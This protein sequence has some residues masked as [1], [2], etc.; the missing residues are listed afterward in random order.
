MWVLFTETLKY[1]H[2]TSSLT[3]N[4]EQHRNLFICS[5][6]HIYLFCDKVHDKFEVGG[7]LQFPI[8]QYQ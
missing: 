6:M 4:G 7:T 3:A 8:R 2:Y 1:I 5:N